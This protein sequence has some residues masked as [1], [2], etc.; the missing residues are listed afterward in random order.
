M[1]RA[2]TI[3]AVLNSV[4][5]CLLWPI[6]KNEILVSLPRRH[7]ISAF[8]NVE[9]GSAF[10][11]KIVLNN[12]TR[13]LRFIAVIWVCVCLCVLPWSWVCVCLCV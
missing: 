1:Y 7:T 12:E 2:E 5:I 13:A 9:M 8:S 10:A 3:F 11:F 6:F 4:R